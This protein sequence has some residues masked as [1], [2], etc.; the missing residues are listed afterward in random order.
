MMNPHVRKSSI[1]VFFSNYFGCV[2]EPRL[3]V[4]AV[5][6][7]K[8]FMDEVTRSRVN[9]VS[10]VLGAIGISG[11]VAVSFSYLVDHSIVL[12]FAA[13]GGISIFIAIT[14]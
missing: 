12:L 1:K 14:A 3:S 7:L 8:G 10:L 5:H 6:W 4:R 9:Q 2:R 13:L 11:V